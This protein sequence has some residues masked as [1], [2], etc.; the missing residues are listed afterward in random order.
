MLNKF[1]HDKYPHCLFASTWQQ[2]LKARPRRHNVLHSSSYIHLL[3]VGYK[4]FGPLT[5]LK[6][7]VREPISVL[8]GGGANISLHC[9]FLFATQSF[10]TEPE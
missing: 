1:Q 10:V 2:L 9:H 4:C 5:G 6:I 8:G 7:S 3:S